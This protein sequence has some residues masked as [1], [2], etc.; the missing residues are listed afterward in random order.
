MKVAVLLLNGMQSFEVACA[1]QVFGYASSIAPPIQVVLV[2]P[3]SL[4]RLDWGV[5]VVA[6]PLTS[7]VRAD[8]V[9]IPGFSSMDA[10]QKSMDRTQS[11]A[12]QAVLAAHAAG[13][14]V[15]S[16]CVGAF[17][18]ASTGLLDE[19]DATT[20]WRRC[21]DLAKAYTNVRVVTNVLYT[22]DVERRVWTSAGETAALDCCLAV[23]AFSLGQATAAA[24]ARQLVLPATRPGGQA[25]FVPPRWGPNPA[26]GDLARLQCLVRDDLGFAWTLAAMARAAQMSTR[27]L[28]RRCEQHWGTSPLKWLIGERLDA[29]KEL[30]QATDESIEAIAHHV[31]FGTSDLLRKHFSSVLGITPSQYR[32]AFAADGARRHESDRRSR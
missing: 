19:T 23:V 18:L 8:V 22:H 27:T 7:M 6:E 13:A 24:A 17:W 5:S 10:L 4:V 11:A 20:H 30:L 32:L 28:Q 31:G 1:C 2:S 21:R 3:Q 9:V 15:V 26:P 12:R 29:A 14:Q 16:L 25:Q